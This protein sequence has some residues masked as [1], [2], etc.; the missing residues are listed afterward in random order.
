MES[1]H[2]PALRVAR[3]PLYNRLQRS[4]MIE[5]KGE[6]SGVQCR[7]RW[8]VVESS[9]NF[10]DDACVLWHALLHLG[11]RALAYEWRRDAARK[12]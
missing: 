5:E 10:Q 8:T 2:P 6:G 4:G 3:R 9:T 12:E 11:P 7:Q 1:S